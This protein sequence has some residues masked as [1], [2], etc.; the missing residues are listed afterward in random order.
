MPMRLNV[1][2]SRK[3]S[4]Q[5]FGSRG[6]SVNLELEF[7]SQLIQEPG[8]LQARIRQLFALVRASLAEE[9]NGGQDQPTPP[10]TSQAALPEPSPPRVNGP[11]GSSKN[12]ARPATPAQIKAL[13]A[14][15][16]HQGLDLA[17]VL[18]QRWQ[19]ERPGDLSLRQA[20]TLIDELK[21]RETSAS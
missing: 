19:V 6:A 17:V 3:V 1:G 12:G 2:A 9:L 14:I 13:H 15:A 21:S 10:T 5:H 20:S 7:D 8:K 16:R 11:N 18:R 4:D